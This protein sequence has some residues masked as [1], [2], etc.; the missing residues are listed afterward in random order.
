MR[1]GGAMMH[2]DFLQQLANDR[3][4]ELERRTSYSSGSSSRAVPEP[5]DTVLLRLCCVG[6]DEAIERLAQLEGKP[7]PVGRHIVA[8][9]DGVV[10]A[11]LPLAGGKLLADPFRATSH[12]LPLLELRA[13]QVN[14]CTN[15]HASIWGAVRSWSRA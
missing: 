9:I 15:G 14:A 11:A 8:E 2:P 1:R 10:I 5:V 4:R 12:L 3:R 6:D 7:A 13:K